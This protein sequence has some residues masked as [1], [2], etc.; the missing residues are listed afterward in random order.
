MLVIEDYV[1]P[2]RIRE[3]LQDAGLLGSAAQLD[4]ARPLPTLRELGR[5]D[6]RLVI[7]AEKEGGAYPWYLPAFSFIQDTPLGNRRPSDFSCERF[8]GDADSPILMLNH[9]IDRF[10][11]RVIDNARISTRTFLRRRIARCTGERDVPGGVVAV[12]FYER[13][14]V[15]GVARELNR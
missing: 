2:A 5:D 11:P 6:R 1:P 15:L 9:W 8:R 13:G 12:D 3:A 14:A 10:P 7:F 4:R